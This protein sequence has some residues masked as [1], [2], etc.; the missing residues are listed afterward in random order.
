MNLSRGDEFALSTLMDLPNNEIS[1]DT[2]ECDYKNE[3][4][5]AILNDCLPFLSDQDLSLIAEDIQDFV[6]GFPALSLCFQYF[7][8]FFVIQLV[9]IRR[10]ILL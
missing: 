2:T 5:I 7:V 8:G 9:S 1:I 3:P 4:F 6:F 10:I